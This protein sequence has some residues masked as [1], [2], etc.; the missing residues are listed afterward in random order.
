MILASLTASSLS[1]VL[2]FGVLAARHW[3]RICVRHAAGSQV[4]RRGA[5]RDDRGI[6][7]SGFGLA[8]VYVAPLAKA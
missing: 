6:V 3:I 2:G 7:V 5:D 8:S 4:V 1:Y